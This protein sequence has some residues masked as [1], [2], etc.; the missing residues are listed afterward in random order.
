M[1]KT[2]KSASKG[3]EGGNPTVITKEQLLKSIE[4]MQEWLV[5]IRKAVE[6]SNCGEHPIEVR[7][8][9][10]YIPCHR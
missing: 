5:V 2:T 6:A 4:M 9:N 7:C 10:T 3:D 1:P 8:P